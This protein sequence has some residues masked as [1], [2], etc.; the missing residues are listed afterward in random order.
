MIRRYSELAPSSGTRI[1]PE[2]R[3]EVLERDGGCV[4]A[5]VG[6]PGPCFGALELDHVRA[7]GG[8]G[9]KSATVK[10]NLVTLCGGHHR[11][12]TEAGRT[13]RPVLLAYLERLEDPHSAHVDPVASCSDCYRAVAAHWPVDHA[14]GNE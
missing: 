3:F 13:W 9:M 14:L 12:K 8:I 1:P 10:A 4:G 7:S 5:L 11:T 2:L 6:M